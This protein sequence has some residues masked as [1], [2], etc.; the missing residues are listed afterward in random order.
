MRVDV[1]HPVGGFFGCACAEIESDLR[2]GADQFA[3]AQEF[4]GAEGVV[5]G[6]S[7]GSVPHADA[8][9]ARADGVAPMIGGGEVSAKADD[10]SVH[11]FGHRDDVGVHAVDVVGRK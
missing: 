6:D 11:G 2:A 9:I 3:E 5:F 8:L 7:P 10:R 1:A 4:V